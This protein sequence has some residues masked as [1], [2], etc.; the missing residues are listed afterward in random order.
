MVKQIFLVI[1]CLLCSGVV[2]ARTDVTQTGSKPVVYLTFDDGPSGDRVTE[3]VLS[4]LE[5]YNAKATFFVTGLR[6]RADPEKVAKIVVA[7]HALGNHTLSHIRMTSLSNH[8][9]IEELSITNKFIYAAGGPKMSCFR[10]P[11][12]ATNARVNSIASRMGMHTVGWSIDTRDWD[13]FVDKHEIAVQL[14]DSHHNSII[15]MHDGPKARWRTLEVFTQW[16]EDSGH[17][18]DFRSLP[19]CVQPY[20]RKS[21]PKFASN[22]SPSQ[23][24][25]RAKIAATIPDLIAKLRRYKFT[26]QPAEV[27]AQTDI[28]STSY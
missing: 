14:E 25:V 8:E 13:V 20:D 24:M 26:L 7:G 16:M 5:R 28:Q 15:L 9:I 2:D 1:T 18:Y 23:P 6:A 19:Q 11:F 22:E 17:L 27:V 12:G 3:E 4:V 10:A 21:D